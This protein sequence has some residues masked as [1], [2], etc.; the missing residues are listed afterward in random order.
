MLIQRGIV[1]N[2]NP[3]Q[4]TKGLLTM[5]VAPMIAWEV[6]S[7]AINNMMGRNDKLELGK[8]VGAG[9]MQ[10][11]AGIPVVRDVA[12][13]ALL[14]YD[15][16]VS[17]MVEPL[18]AGTTTMY[19]LE[20]SITGDKEDWSE[21]DLLTALEATGFAFKLPTRAFTTAIDAYYKNNIGEI[22]DP[23]AYI[24]KPPRQK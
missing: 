2:M 8:A 12:S 4:V 11:T 16:Q 21:S 15:Y 1:K 20:Q 22:N 24:S 7:T 3:A 13:A 19:N 18:K 9:L 6:G 23:F 5:L 14:G 17:P 10:A